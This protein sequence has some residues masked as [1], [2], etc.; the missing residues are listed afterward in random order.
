MPTETAPAPQPRG[1]GDEPQAISA[2]ELRA[3]L[4]RSL[5]AKGVLAQLKVRTR[6]DRRPPAIASA[7]GEPDAVYINRHL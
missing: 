4:F 5:Q 1:A 6:E 2:E 3:H 7:I